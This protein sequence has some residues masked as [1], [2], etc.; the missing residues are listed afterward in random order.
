L[1]KSRTVRAGLGKEVCWIEGNATPFGMF[2]KL[3]QHRHEMVVVDDVDNLYS[4]Q[5]SVRLLKCLCQTEKEKSL[6][7]HS[8]AA[9]LER[10]GIPREFTTQSRVIIIANEWKT[11]NGNV[12]A[13][14]DRGHLVSFEPLP[15]EVHREVSAWLQDEEI[16]T[17]FGR[18]LAWYD[19]LSMRDYVRAAELKQA[20][21]DWRSVSMPGNV[22]EKTRLVAQLKDD[23]SF[24]MEEDRAKRFVSLGA[25][26]RATYF[27]HAKKLNG[28]SHSRNRGRYRTVE[29]DS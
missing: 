11:L 10:R 5:S 24:P 3:Y 21:L 4:N 16:L 26:C 14:Q 29:V 12:A 1:A 17:W 9:G 25:G 8:A 28:C 15:E 2:L 13:V 23:P 19:G 18:H 20:G 22:P 7:W 27:N 6:A